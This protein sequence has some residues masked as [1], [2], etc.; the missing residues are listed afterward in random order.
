M[1][2]LISLLLI[3]TASLSAYAQKKE[4][5]EPNYFKNLYTGDLLNKIEF[6]EFRQKLYTD[7][8]DSIRR[9]V[10]ITMRFVSL[11]SSNDSII[12]SFNYDL[13]VGKK[14]IKRANTY[15]KIGMNIPSRTFQTI[16]GENIKIGGNQLKPTLINLWF[17]GCIGCVEEIPALNR[18]KEKYADKV[19]FVALTFDEKASVVQF[20]KKKKFNYLHIPNCEDFINEIGSYPYPENIFIDRNGTIRYIEGG[21][22][23]NENTDLVIK[24]FESILDEL[25]LQTQVNI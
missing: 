13:R 1:S 7:F 23:Y 5:P 24:H 4:R 9:N 11:K 6:E 14:Y 19:N 25:L 3:F 17:I 16:E 18:L 10:N 8:N 21:L 12:Q 15:N 22:P 20:L 2:R